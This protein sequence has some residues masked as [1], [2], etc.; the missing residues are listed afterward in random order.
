VALAWAQEKNKTGKG[1]N[2]TRRVRG[3]GAEGGG[4][5][6]AGASPPMVLTILAIHWK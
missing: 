1:A 6:A 3:C 4:P 5:P 2:K